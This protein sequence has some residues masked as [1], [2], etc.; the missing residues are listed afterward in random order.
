MCVCKPKETFIS[1]FPNIIINCNSQKTGIVVSSAMTAVM[2]IG[3][4]EEKLLDK[5]ISLYLNM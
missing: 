5:I 1:T 2:Q 4:S 3:L